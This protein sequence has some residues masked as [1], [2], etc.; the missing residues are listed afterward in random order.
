[1]D[2]ELQKIL[3]HLRLGGLLAQWDELLAEARRGRFSHERLLQHVLQAEYRLK[4]EQARILRR[5]RAHIP[6]ILEYA[7]FR[8]M[9][10]D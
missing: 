9:R 10:S 7:E 8:I 4:T 5:K 2:E 6:E 1:M 3:K